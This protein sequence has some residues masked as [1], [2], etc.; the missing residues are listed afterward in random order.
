MRKD[1]IG[2][3][4]R[5]PIAEMGLLRR[6][7]PRTCRARNTNHRHFRREISTLS[8]REQPQLNGG[9]KTARVGDMVSPL[10]LLPIQLWKPI[11]EITCIICEAEIVTQ[12]YNLNRGRDIVRLQILLRLTMSHTE[13]EKID[14]LK[15][16]LRKGEVAPE[17]IT[18]HRRERLPI[19]ALTRHIRELHLRVVQQNP[20]ELPGRIT[21]APS[22]SN[23]NHI[24]HPY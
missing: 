2:G 18:M 5:E 7:L 17:Q 14:L 22:N 15:I 8:E 20:Q 24:F 13:K 1:L 3:E 12:I 19:M 6:L 11:D 10:N 23:L 21:G 4:I 9:G 16:D